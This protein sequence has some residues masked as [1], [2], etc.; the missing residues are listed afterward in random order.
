M[1]RK[2][3]P[4]KKPNQAHALV[5]AEPQGGVFGG[6]ESEES[7][8]AHVAKRAHALDLVEPKAGTS[9]VTKVKKVNPPSRGQTGACTR[10]GRAPGR[11]FQWWEK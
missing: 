1:V 6:G 8:P 11:G 7:G 10:F 2:V 5:L 4:P 3:A 9:V